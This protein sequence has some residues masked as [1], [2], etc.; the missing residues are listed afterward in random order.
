M[1]EGPWRRPAAEGPAAERGPGSLA[2]RVAGQV[3]DTGTPVLS[4]GTGDGIRHT[5]WEV[6]DPAALAQI[7]AD[8]APRQALIADGNHRYAAYLQMQADRRAAGDGAGPVG[9]RARAAGQRGRV[10]AA[11]RGDPPGAAR[12]A[13]G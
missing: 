8:L 1:A 11:D 5:L 10:P 13:P 6:T 12:A 3:A 9:L 2:T 7:A 4:T